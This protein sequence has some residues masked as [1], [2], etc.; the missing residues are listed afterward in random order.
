MLDIR[1]LRLR[2]CFTLENSLTGEEQVIGD[3][4]TKDS[5]FLIIVLHVI[6][7]KDLQFMARFVLLIIK[8]N[9]RIGGGYGLI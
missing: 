7:A 6:Q 2:V 4:T 3:R 8:I 1:L 5:C 9:L